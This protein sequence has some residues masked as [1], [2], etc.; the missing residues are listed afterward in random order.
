MTS[1]GLVSMRE[2]VSEVGG[3][4]EIYSAIGKGT[5][6]EIRIPVMIDVAKGVES[7]DDSSY[8]GG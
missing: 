7:D 8:A 1:Y 5:Q 4:M 2:R 6:I 3:S